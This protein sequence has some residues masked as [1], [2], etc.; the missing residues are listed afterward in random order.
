MMDLS[1]VR[2]TSS[3][4]ELQTTVRPELLRG[5]PLDVCLSGCGQHFAR[6]DPGMFKVD[7]RLYQLSRQMKRFHSFLSHDWSTSRWM[8]LMSLLV[9]Y[10]SRA[11]FLSSLLVSL[12]VGILR[13]A[14]LIPD[15]LWPTLLAYSVFPFVLFFWQRI[16]SVLLRSPV[17][18]FFDKLCIAQH[19]EELKRN[20]IFGLAGFLDHAD[21]LTVLWS[22]RY[23]SRLWCTYEISTFLRDSK[24]KPI[25][26]MPVKLAVVFVI[27]SAAMHVVTL[28]FSILMYLRNSFGWKL[29][30]SLTPVPDGDFRNVLNENVLYLPFLGPVMPLL[31]YIGIGMMEELAALPGQ[32]RHFRV[33]DAKCFCC[34]NEHCHPESGEVMPCDRLLIFKMLKRWYGRQSDPKGEKLYLER[35]NKLVQ[36]EL[37]PK[38]LRSMGNDMLPWNY[39][40]YMLIP[41]VL[42]VLTSLIPKMM[43]GQPE[44]PNASQQVIWA[45]RLLM[46]WSMDG[47]LAL[48]WIRLSMWIWLLAVRYLPHCCSKYPVLMAFLLTMPAGF[49][50]T[51][52][53]FSSDI[54]MQVSE[55]DS[56]LPA[57]PFTLW[58]FIL[59][60]LW[61]QRSVSVLGPKAGAVLGRSASADLESLESCKEESGPEVNGCEECTECPKC[62]ERNECNECNEYHQGNVWNEYI[63]V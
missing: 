28:G 15:G 34:S 62:N 57:I 27:F 40:F 52:I 21:E 46:D 12:S 25:L 10:N 3:L 51:L 14:E 48:F 59:C 54:C 24:P 45:L 13:V 7:H 18:V 26:V 31:Y 2:I 17:T 61:S 23:F 8:K 41:G 1:V 20:G 5:V 19:D 55:D 38:I 53:L 39:S 22:G 16:R 11:A 44:L 50:L 30:L 58:L 35:F 6:P 56:M 33:Q 36:E 47:I 43:A 49:L 32:L 63:S 4:E 9:L 37:A 60:G 29:Q 42:P